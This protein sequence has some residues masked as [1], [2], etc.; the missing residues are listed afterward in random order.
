[1]SIH[2]A[3]ALCDDTYEQQKSLPPLSCMFLYPLQTSALMSLK[4]GFGKAT[5]FF[6]NMQ[7]GSAWRN[8]YD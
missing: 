1:M 4:Y 5:L 6:H 7:Q 3:L 2:L 8:E